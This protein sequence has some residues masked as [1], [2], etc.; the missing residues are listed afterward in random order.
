MKFKHFLNFIDLPQIGTIE[1]GEPIGFDSSSYKVKRDKKRFGRDLIIANEE[2]DLTF[3]RSYFEQMEVT[4]M[5]PNGE[6]ISY[7]SNGFDFLLDVFQNEGWESQIEYI[8]QKDGIDFVTGIFSY[9]TAVVEFDQIKVKIVQN[10]NR[11]II[12]R[13]DDTDIDAFNSVALDDRV[14]TPCSTTN[15]LLKAKPIIQLSSWEM[16]E[17]RTLNVNINDVNPFMNLLSYGVRASYTPF[18]QSVTDN[19]EAIKNFRYIL[20]QTSLSNGTGEIYFNGV[21]R[22]R[23]NGISDTDA[24]FRLLMLQYDGIY[25]IGVPLII[26]EIYRKAFSGG[27]NSD[28]LVDETFNFDLPNLNQGQSLTFY[29]VFSAAST[30]V[31][32]NNQ[33]TFNN[34]SMDLQYTSTAIDTVVKGVRLIDLMK[35]NVKSLNDTELNAPIYESGGEHY[36]NFTFNGLL[37]GQITDKPFYNKFK[38]L[39]TIP[40]EVCAD[41]QINE[42]NVEI[43]PYNEFYN[44]VEMAVFEQLSDYESQTKMNPIY[45]MKTANYKYKKSSEGR[46]TNGENSI[47]DVHTETQKYLSNMV[48]GEFK[49][50][51]NHIRSAYLIEEARQRAFDLEQ[52][53]A[54]ENDDS[55]FLLDCIELAPSTKGGFGAVLLM[56]I[57]ETG[58]LQ[59]L[60]NNLNGDGI[61]FNWNLLGFAVGGQL[62]IDS[63]ENVGTWQ[64]LSITDSVLELFPISVTA[65]FEGDAYIVMSWFFNDVSFTN[66]TNEGF[67]LIE[68]VD[69]PS[70]YSNLNYHWARNIQRWRPYLATAT[71][72]KPNGTIKTTSFKTNG[73]LVTRKIGEIADVSDSAEINNIDIAQYKILNPFVHS[74]KVYSDFEKVTQ[75][76]KDIA[77]VKGYVSVRLND[78][79][80]V[81]GFINE[82]DYDWSKEE[83]QLEIEEK[84]IS[85]YMEITP[86]GITLTGYDEKSYLESFQI[87]NNFVLLFDA[88]S[89][90]LFPPIRFTLIKING[91]LFTDL[92]AFTDALI[93]F[94]N[95]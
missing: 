33:I 1:I 84:F 27:A 11:E 66:R 89:L 7:A 75:L 35:H 56:R 48:D 18:E 88:N 76:I 90:Q 42:N 12:K 77:D 26:T 36:N 83:L 16:A 73:N 72:F 5:L 32:G 91:I 34:Y 38:D 37:L 82:M 41:Y 50:D 4:Q 52:S 14:I 8:L 23:P 57:T 51:L 20:A 17:S 92:T 21:L 87:N 47:D 80:N 29:W 59:I 24:S 49:V 13:L 62:F 67:T 45:A 61:N 6:I 60:N 22:Y 85:D 46:E 94:I 39:M 74:I 70:K 9:F 78:G 54:L 69:N 65:S 3:T 81:K 25:E 30:G 2:T 53:K 28:F 71:K 64:V 40:S 44:D 31:I 19:I 43:L 10:T 55:L 79:R 63:G 15:I 86:S 68:G 93:D 58:H 95:E